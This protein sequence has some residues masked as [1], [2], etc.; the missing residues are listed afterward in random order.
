MF[1]GVVLLRKVVILLGEIFLSLV[2]SFILKLV[3]L[4]SGFD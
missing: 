3:V 1:V 4:S 2:C